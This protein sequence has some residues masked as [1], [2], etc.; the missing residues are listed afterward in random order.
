MSV[1]RSENW[2]VI[3]D[4]DGV[5]VDSSE[6]HYRSW[7]AW[8][9]EVEDIDLADLTREWFGA[10]FGS[11]NGSI[12]PPLFQRPLG[13]AE[14]TRH[15]DRKEELFRELA[16][17]HLEPLPG[18]SELVEGLAQ[19]GIP[20]AIGSSTPPENLLIVLEEIGLASFFPAGLRVCGADVVKGK[21][22]PEVFLAAAQRLGLP[23]AR[24]VVIEDAGVGVRAARAA[25]IA[26]IGVTT[27]RPTV[28][29][30]EAGADWIVG[31][32]EDVIIE[33]MAKLVQVRGF[34]D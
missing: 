1:N 10:T 32:L 24:C 30:K 11:R 22:D 6:F 16:V 7:L 34:A 26:C 25:G 21:P 14:I 20:V 33:D 17:G 31:S 13:E 2:G 9:Q 5:L 18:A 8:G 12:I 3:F 27:T 4:L 15:A 19:A 28:R 23:P 29:L